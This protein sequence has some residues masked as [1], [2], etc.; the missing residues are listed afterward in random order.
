MPMSFLYFPFTVGFIGIRFFSQLTWV[1]PKPHGAT[2]ISFR[3]LIWQEVNNQIRRICWKFRTI[4]IFK[5]CYVSCKLNGC[6]M[7]SQA[8]P[9]VRHLIFPRKPYCVDLSFNPSI[10]KSSRHQN[11]VALRQLLQSIFIFEF[12][13]IP[14]VKFNTNIISYSTMNQ[15]FGEAFI[16]FFKIDIF[17]DNSNFNFSCGFL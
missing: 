4:C 5:F 2:H 11:S 15:S 6:T 9:K 14:P 13:C 3:I 7:H 10:S 1:L 16:R 12:F 8:N 17:S